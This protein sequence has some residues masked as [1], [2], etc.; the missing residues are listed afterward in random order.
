MDDF[1]ALSS[2]LAHVLLYPRQIFVHP[3][4]REGVT[5]LRQNLLLIFWSS[6]NPIHKY[7]VTWC[8]PLENRHEHT[9]PQNWSLPQLRSPHQGFWN[10]H[11]WLRSMAGY[12]S[13]WKESSPRVPITGVP[14]TLPSAQFSRTNCD[15]ADLSVGLGALLLG[16][17]LHW[18]LPANEVLHHSFTIICLTSSGWWDLCPWRST[19]TPQQWVEVERVLT[20][21]LGPCTWWEGRLGGCPGC[22]GSVATAS[23]CRCRSPE[24]CCPSLGAGWS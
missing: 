22:T 15:P 19:P 21:G 18:C 2:Y 23:R 14:S 17:H 12:D 16:H 1:D 13:P 4:W 10:T 8:K 9:Q 6:W 11:Q 24:S 7:F 3:G 5:Y 20:E